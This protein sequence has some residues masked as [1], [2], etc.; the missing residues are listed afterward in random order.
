[1]ST[2]EEREFGSIFYDQVVEW[3]KNNHDPD[4]IFDKEVL[5]KWIKE[6]YDPSEIYDLEEY[7]YILEK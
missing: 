7:G 5:L 3:I 4:E 6:E 1:M 2:W